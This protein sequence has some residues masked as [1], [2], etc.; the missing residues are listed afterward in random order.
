MKKVARY[1]FVLALLF[2]L[3]ACSFG[4]TTTEVESKELEK[5][6]FAVTGIEGIEELDAKYEPFRAALEEVLGYP[7]EFYALT[8]NAS[9]VTALENKEADFILAGGS[10][11]VMIKDSVDSIYALA[12]ITRP[13]YI[14]IIISHK[15]SGIETIAD[16]QPEHIIGTRNVGSTSGHLMPLKMLVDAGVDLET[17]ITVSVLG[18]SNEEAFLTGEIDLLPTTL[19]NYQKIKTEGIASYNIIL[20]GDLLPNDLL[21]AGGHLDSAYIEGIRQA[22]LENS[23]KLIGSLL[24]SGENEKYSNS[25]FIEARDS[26][27]DDLREAYRILGIDF[28]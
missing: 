10:D 6:A 28:N 16:I 9:A 12:A 8:D 19:L 23:D 13:G 18:N 24:A 7:V 4:K 27:Y 2:G 22:I 21:V 26:E 1:L 15:D 11:Y 17:G 25:T 5:I 14:P 3:V 20:Q